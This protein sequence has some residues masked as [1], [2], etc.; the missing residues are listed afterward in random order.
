MLL[1]FAGQS[2]A[3]SA[4]DLEIDSLQR[5]IA[6]AAPDTNKVETYT[7]L[8]I[9]LYAR[10]ILQGRKPPDSIA[11]LQNI[12]AG[13]SLSK[14][15]N[16]HFGHG[17][18]YIW[19]AYF[20]N[21]LEN[22]PKRDSLLANGF[23]IFRAGNEKTGLAD[24]YFFK[25][26]M[27]AGATTDSAR[28]I[29]YDSAIILAKESGNTKREAQA[30]RAIADIH[31]LQG[32]ATKALEILNQVLELQQRT[33]DNR[34]HFTSDMLASTY[35]GVGNYKESLRHAI[36]TIAYA[37]QNRDTGMIVT[38]YQRLGDTYRNMY[39][40]EKSYYYYDKAISSYMP[41]NEGLVR[42]VTESIL[43]G[44]IGA[45]INQKKFQQ[46]SQIL[47]DYQKKFSITDPKDFGFL[48]FCFLDIYL[49]S[50]D[51]KKAEKQFM[52]MHQHMNDWPDVKDF[53]IRLYTR[54]G[55][56]Y[57]RL[58][59]PD[60][61]VYYSD[62]A[63]RMGVRYKAWS[64]M[65]DNSEVLYR[66]DSLRGNHKEALRHQLVF[67]AMSDSIQ[68]DISNKQLA[69]LAVQ[70]E[71]DQKNSELASLASQ[72]NLQ[73][74]TIHKGTLLRNAMIAGSGL[75]LLLLFVTY[76]RFRI[77]KKA[78]ALLQEKQDEINWQNTVLERM[79]VE[80]KKIT[81]EKDKLLVEK[82]WLMKEINHRVKNNL[83]V[84]MS[85]LSSQ[86]SYLK[87]E[88]A[89][90]AI[91]E[92]RHRV[93]AISL[94][95]RKLYQSDRLMTVIDM[96]TYIKEVVEYLSDNLDV[97]SRISFALNIE[98]IMLDVTQAVPAG[99]I[100]NEAVTNAVKYAFPGNSKGQISIR[101]HQMP[102]DRIELIISDN[103]I[104]LPDNFNW[105]HA[106]SLGMSLM[107][108]LTRQLDGIFT[109]EQDNGLTIRIIFERSKSPAE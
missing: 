6:Q 71:T 67:K 11:F 10:Y 87:D 40:Y 51:Y 103:G 74:E 105:Q 70:Y 14:K 108:G 3:Q 21:F 37:R 1:A 65:M 79:V 78:N 98:P 106:E 99:L 88:A 53:I 85:L 41:G 12:H 100:I 89:L 76:N 58:N 47:S 95:H 33:K 32:N 44:M 28:L 34:I 19:Q 62:S 16:D 43:N 81:E 83:Q 38:F 64:V 50:G 52:L 93:H 59:Q 46:A 66:V 73:Q 82:E 61:A 69:E 109:V 30:L 31:R 27:R 101:M 86:S 90:N 75:L 18:S 17:T 5:S 25:A 24:A 57:W 63:F 72:N 49:Y 20:Y 42:G 55:Q 77:K 80:E 97:N 84:V 22:Y 54:A 102:D 23:S 2:K 94:I 4:L 60:K 92:S 8:C 7:T 56:L 35:N 9:K 48:N 29:L 104:G 107:N 96:S 15:L 91:H 45:L 13:R 26:E 68:R 36:A 39:N